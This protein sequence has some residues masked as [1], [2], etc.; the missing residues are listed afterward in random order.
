MIGFFERGARM[1]KDENMEKIRQAFLED[2]LDPDALRGCVGFSEG[3]TPRKCIAARK[4]LGWSQ[5]TL[6][7]EAGL[8]LS[9]VSRFE[10]GEIKPR[11]ATLEKLRA[12]FARAGIDV[13]GL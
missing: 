11:E 1:L 3:I 9:T 12:T 13:D 5:V 4:S 8:V 2:G 6:A 10:R 7:V